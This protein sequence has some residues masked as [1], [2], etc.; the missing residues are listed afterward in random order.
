MAEASLLFVRDDRTVADKLARA[1]ESNGVTICASV[2]ALEEAAGYDAVVALFSGTAVKSPLL[3][4]RALQA[5]QEGKLVPVFVGL[6]HLQPPLNK[7]VF[8]DLCEWQ[9]D[10]N[11]V[12]LQAIRSHVMRIARARST[13]ELLRAGMRPQEPEPPPPPPPTPD[14]AEARR[15]EDETRRANQR[16]EQ[17]QTL[18]RLDREREERAALRAQEEAA[19]RRRAAEDQQARAQARRHSPSQESPLPQAAGARDT[20]RATGQPRVAAAVGAA[21]S[22]RA[23]LSP[24]DRQER[25]RHHRAR[26]LAAR[27]AARGDDFM[28]PMV[29]D[30][31]SPH[32]DRDPGEP[33]AVRRRT[34]RAD[35]DDLEASRRP[36]RRRFGVAD[37]ASDV[38]VVTLVAVVA[39][40]AILI[41]AQPE[42][43]RAV[44]EGVNAEVAAL[45]QSLRH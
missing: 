18:A 37:W 31:D 13:D 17:E 10:P 25:E 45:L 14:P 9:G 3:M 44:A 4:E 39:V 28:R 8:H 26:E 33:S 16:R 36:A 7:L 21:A 5:E 20:D 34:G 30:R 15:R 19:A 6:C 1:L 35:H 23:G 27:Q 24:E 38:L 12:A 22:E 2:S 29:V 32:D 41:A 40:A 42:A 43:A 11:D